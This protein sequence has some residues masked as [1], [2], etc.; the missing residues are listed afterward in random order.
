M[1]TVLKR[2]PDG[3]AEFIRSDAGDEE[4]IFTLW[5]DGRLVV[6]TNDYDAVNEF[7]TLIENNG[8]YPRC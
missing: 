8:E 3:V 1:H 7:F 2:T 6:V 4:T 5:I